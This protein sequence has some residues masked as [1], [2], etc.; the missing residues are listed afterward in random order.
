MCICVWECM[1]EFIISIALICQ[2]ARVWFVKFI[3]KRNLNFLWNG[4]YHKSYYPHSNYNR[5]CDWCIKNMKF[6]ISIKLD[7][8]ITQIH[9]ILLY[10]VRRWPNHL[11]HSMQVWIDWILYA[12]VNPQSHC[13]QNNT[14]WTQSQLFFT[15]EA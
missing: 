12:K 7:W 3:C 14:K 2:I 15:F 10:V 6:V 8:T 13:T 1:C 11:T 5:F 4:A 9:Q